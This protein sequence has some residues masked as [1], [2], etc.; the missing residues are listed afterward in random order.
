MLLLTFKQ[1][2]MKQFLELTQKDGQQVIINVSHIVY[3]KQ[4]FKNVTIGLNHTNCTSIE[5]KESFNEIKA[6][7]ELPIIDNGNDI[8]EVQ[9][10]KYPGI[11]IR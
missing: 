10:W 7:L 6:L 2:K 3:V 1:K 8:N 9:G 4:Q 5:V 11:T